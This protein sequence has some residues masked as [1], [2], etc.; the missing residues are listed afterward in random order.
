[1]YSF[2]SVRGAVDEAAHFARVERGVVIDTHYGSQLQW[3]S[4][5]AKEAA[6]G[7]ASGDAQNRDMRGDRNPVSARGF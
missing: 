2:L 1:M 7:P 4:Q 5:E 3:T 6:A